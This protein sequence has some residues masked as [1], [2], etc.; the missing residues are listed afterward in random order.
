MI[1][2]ESFSCVEI[3]C[4]IYAPWGSMNG[5]LFKRGDCRCF[6]AGVPTESGRASSF[7]PY[8]IDEYCDDDN[9]FIAHQLHEDD[10]ILGG[11]SECK[12]NK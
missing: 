9:I 5:V 8:K 10:K 12:Y 4:E 1:G 11:C 6:W 7:C 2:N 3:D